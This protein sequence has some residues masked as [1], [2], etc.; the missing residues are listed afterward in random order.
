M[1]EPF[2]NKK[3]VEIYHD[4]KLNKEEI[5][6]KIY[7]TFGIKMTY[8]TVL[9]Y[10]ARIGCGTRKDLGI[11]KYKLMQC[12]KHPFEACVCAGVAHG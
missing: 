5:V 11:R 10:V 3:F 1:F 8:N 4:P 9:V 7:K 6:K 12:C 2:N